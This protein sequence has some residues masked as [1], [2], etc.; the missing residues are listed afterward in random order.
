MLATPGLAPLVA[1]AVRT[2]RE[3]AIAAGDP[4]GDDAGPGWRAFSDAFPTFYEFSNRP[5]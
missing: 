2:W 5:R 4:G 3:R 1:D